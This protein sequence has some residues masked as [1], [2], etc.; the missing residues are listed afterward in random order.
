MNHNVSLQSSLTDFEA[1][2]PLLIA[3]AMK[4]LTG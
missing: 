4:N 2:H 1:M 3:A